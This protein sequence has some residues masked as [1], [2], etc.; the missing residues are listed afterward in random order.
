VNFSV[1]GFP[2]HLWQKGRS[3]DQVFAPDEW[4]YQRI[5]LRHI[6]P[7]DG[8]LSSINSP[9]RFPDASVNRDKYSSCPEDVLYPADKFSEHGVAGF[10]TCDVLPA[11]S[12]P[13]EGNTTPTSFVFQVTHVPCEFNYAHS[14]VRSVVEGT[15]NMKVPGN[16]TKSEF[17]RHMAKVS[18]IIREPKT[19]S[20]DGGENSG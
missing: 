14:E 2:E 7:D 18:E 13:K 16:T 17:R 1:D 15:T 19:H 9:F 8:K 4:L 12:P 20:A 6:Q 11:Y 5:E 10:K 3:E